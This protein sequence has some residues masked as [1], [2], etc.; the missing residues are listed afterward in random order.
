MVRRFDIKYMNTRI[1]T[2]CPDHGLATMN[3]CICAHYIK[4]DTP[5]YICHLLD[6]HLVRDEGQVKA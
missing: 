6:E 3:Q 2:I 1:E 4:R 5:C